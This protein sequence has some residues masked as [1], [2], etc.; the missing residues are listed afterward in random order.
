MS[1]V[2]L[3]PTIVDL[4]GFRVEGGSYDGVNAF[5]SGETSVAYASCWYSERCLA[6][7]D[8]RRKVISHFDHLPPEAYDLLADP[9]E[10]QNVFGEEDTELLADLHDWKD[11]QLTRFLQHLRP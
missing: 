1:Q 3:L 5:A 9:R 4:L 7:V 11:Q 8:R 10:T 2:D 6:R